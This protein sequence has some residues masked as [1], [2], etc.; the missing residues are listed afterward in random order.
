MRVVRSKAI[1]CLPDCN[2]DAVSLLIRRDYA[3]LLLNERNNF[4]C[5]WHAEQHGTMATREVKSHALALVQRLLA[6][7]RGIRSHA[8]PYP[9]SG[10]DG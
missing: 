6:T 1:R 3:R 8:T 10:D 2:D 7:V 5:F 9:T 4:G